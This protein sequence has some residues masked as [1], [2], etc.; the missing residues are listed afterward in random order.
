MERPLT[1]KLKKVVR[2]RKVCLAQADLTHQRKGRS[3]A[4]FAWNQTAVAG[5]E[6][7]SGGSRTGGLRLVFSLKTF[8]ESLDEA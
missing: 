7:N 4:F 1:S 5:K 8:V 2:V 3:V 6:Q